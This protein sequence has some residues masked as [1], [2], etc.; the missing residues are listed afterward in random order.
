MNAKETSMPIREELQQVVARWETLDGA[1]RSAVKKHTANAD[2]SVTIELA[3][4]RRILTDLA[5]E[6]AAAEQGAP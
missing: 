1:K 5:I 4:G 2:G 6:R 3:D